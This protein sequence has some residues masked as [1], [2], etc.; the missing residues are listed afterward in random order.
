[1]TW[2]TE[3]LQ[4]LVERR[5]EPPAVVAQLRLG[6]L[7]AWGEGWVKKRWEPAADVLGADGSLFGG[8][9]AALADQ[10]L[11]FAAMTCVPED[12]VFRTANLQVQ[13]LKIGTAR[14]VDIDARVLAHGRRVIAVEAEFRQ[15][16]VLIAKAFA[17]QIVLPGGAG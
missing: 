15:E 3:R 8:H 1:M 11:T 7:D 4:A 13:F 16:G 6:T 17:Q 2:A 14:P 10:V 5:A 9:L 12:C